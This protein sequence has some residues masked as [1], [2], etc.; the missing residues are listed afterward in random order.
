MALTFLFL[1]LTQ[2]FGTLNPVFIKFATQTIPPITFSALR[3]L[4][5]T[6]ILL[7]F[8]YKKKEIIAKKDLYKILPFSL[9]MVFYS[10][11]IQ[12]T[13]VVMSGILYSFVPIFVA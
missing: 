3:F 10:I 13:S 2:L 9:N 7:P 11:G 12:Y 4:L 1:F 6:I 8:W 5:A